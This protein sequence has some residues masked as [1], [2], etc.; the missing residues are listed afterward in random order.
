[1]TSW[2]LISYK[3]FCCNSSVGIH[4]DKGNLWTFVSFFT[5]FSVVLTHPTFLEAAEFP[6]GDGFPFFVPSQLR[7][8]IP[9]SQKCVCSVWYRHCKYCWALKLLLTTRI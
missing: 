7:T 4:L 9:H 5:E 8:H 1:V 6:N 3:F 2:Y